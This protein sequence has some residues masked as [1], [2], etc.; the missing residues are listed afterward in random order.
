MPATQ[1]G[2]S[3]EIYATRRDFSLTA[4][5]F[6]LAI[7]GTASPG[8]FPLAASVLHRARAPTDGLRWRGGEDL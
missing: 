8:Q 5:V 7:H 2:A 4:N 6:T 1:E 3:I